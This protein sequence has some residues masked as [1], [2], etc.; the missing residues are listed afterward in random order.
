MILPT[1]S[2]PAT[3]ALCTEIAKKSKGTIF[4]GFSGGKDSLAAWLQLRKFFTR[5]I[6]FHCASIPNLDYKTKYL[7]Y[8]E[9]QFQTKILRLM[10]EDLPMALVRYV[11]QE[12]PWACDEID[13][14]L[15]VEDY[16]KVE[17]LEYLRYKFNLPRAWC[18]FGI[19]ASDSID[20]RIYCNKT[21][22]KNESHRSFYP[23]WD[24]PRSEI[25]GAIRDSGIKLSAEYRYAK[26]SMGGVPSATYNKIMREHFPRD[27][28]KLLKW[29]PLAE[30]KD[31]R[32]EL[33]EQNY[34]LIQ[35][36][37][38]AA[39]GGIESAEENP[40]ITGEP[41]E[42][43]GIFVADIEFDETNGEP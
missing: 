31:Y 8:L 25:I 22:G 30:T 17:I 2:T 15:E 12:S 7:D 6:P 18:A 20:R 29:Y 43:K 5:I 32:E 24:W 27:F 36:E 35:K 19:S 11:Y 34:L 41:P 40:E 39:R 14:F 37:K 28:E 42:G 9:E 21:G 23:C 13:Q 4:F 16:S 26:R 1:Y 38:A 33:L 10:G 3:D